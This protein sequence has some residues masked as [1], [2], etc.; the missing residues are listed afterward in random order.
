M[1]EWTEWAKADGAPPQ[2]QWRG[3][4][5]TCWVMKDGVPFRTSGRIIELRNTE[6]GYVESLFVIPN[7]WTADVVA[8]M[9]G[10][11]TG[12]RRFKRTRAELLGEVEA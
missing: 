7:G 6:N 4:D 8:T 3:Q 12:F 1:N 5:A 9:I 2:Y 11:M 10:P